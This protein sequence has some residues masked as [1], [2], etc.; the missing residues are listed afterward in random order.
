MES[1][2][3]LKRA[4]APSFNPFGAIATAGRAIAGAAG[5]LFS[6]PPA[7]APKPSTIPHRMPHSDPS[8]SPWQTFLIDAGTSSGELSKNA[9]LSRAVEEALGAVL[10]KVPASDGRGGFDISALTGEQ[11]TAVRKAIIAAIS[12]LR[13]SV[14]CSKGHETRLIGTEAIIAQNADYS[15]G[16]KCD[17]CGGSWHLSEVEPMHCSTCTNFD[18]CLECA[19]QAASK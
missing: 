1:K 12:R 3:F 17:I 15:L 8:L 2:V 4:A 11:R 5:K 6:G 19:L 14:K 10:G 16:F 13:T 9:E 18:V 7:A